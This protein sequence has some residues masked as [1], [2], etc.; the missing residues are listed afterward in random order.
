MCQKYARKHNK[1]SESLLVQ[2]ACLKS[3][4]QCEENNLQIVLQIYRETGKHVRF[5]IVYM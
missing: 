2:R 1:D 5:E 4:V 3:E